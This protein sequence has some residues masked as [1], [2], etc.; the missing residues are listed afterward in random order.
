MNNMEGWVDVDGYNGLYKIS[1]MGNLLSVRRH[2]LMKPSNADNGYSRVNLMKTDSFN[3]NPRGAKMGY[4]HR[5]VAIAFIP[6]PHN[7]PWVNH[8]NGIKSDN[9]VDNLEWGTIRYNHLH[10]YQTGL[11]VSIKGS[12]VHS[13]KLTEFQAMDIFV[14]QQ[15]TRVLAVQYGVHK[16]TINAIRAK[17]AWRHMHSAA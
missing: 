11:H 12:S 5:L 7:H 13:H 1:N 9:R 8:K 10:A 4:I 16:N 2:R 17:R 15:S 6:N 14:S 3:P